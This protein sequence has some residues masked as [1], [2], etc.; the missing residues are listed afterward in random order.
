VS[1]NYATSNLSAIAGSDYTA[2]SGTVTVL[3]GQTSATFT[4]WATGDTVPEAHEKFLV[5][6]SNPVGATVSQPL[7]VG[8]IVNDD[9][10]G[11]SIADVTKS[12]GTGPNTVFTFTVTLSNVAPGPMSVLLTTANSTAIAGGNDYWYKTLTVSFVKGQKTATFSIAVRGDAVP[13]ANETFFVNLANP[14]GTGAKLTD[15]QGIGTILN[16]D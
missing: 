7:A 11:M 14:T 9:G 3:A 2:A 6:L 16:D 10:I 5:T 4:V 15:A 13:E 1:V 12:E 8:W